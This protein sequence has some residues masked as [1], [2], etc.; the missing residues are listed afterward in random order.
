[1]TVPDRIEIDTESNRFLWRIV[2]HYWP[3]SLLL[4]QIPQYLLVLSRCH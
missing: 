3:H 2:H 1:M 4:N